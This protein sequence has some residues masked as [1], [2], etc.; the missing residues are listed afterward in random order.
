MSEQEHHNQ[1]TAE[2]IDKNNVISAFAYIIFFLPLVACP[3]SPFGKFHAN[4]ALLLL[5]TGI[6]GSIVIKMIPVIGWILLPFFSVLIVIVGVICLVNAFNGKARE[7]PIVGK[8]R[9]IK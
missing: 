7:L 5:T 3:D 1:F 4:Q 8:Y 9:I 2:D 6:V